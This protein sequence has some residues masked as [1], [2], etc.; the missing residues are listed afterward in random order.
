MMTPIPN[1]PDYALSDSGYVYN[2]KTKRRMKRQWISGVWRSHVRRA[3][4][5]PF[6]VRHD[7]ILN[8]DSGDMLDREVLKPIPDFQRYA[9][10]PY[11][12]VWCVRPA[13]Y[14]P[15]AGRPYIVNEHL[16]SK[17]RYVKLSDKFGKQKN[18]PVARIM[19]L[20][21]GQKLNT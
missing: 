17:R 3:D 4:G 21:Y 20:V 12:A 8:P 2:V 15:K 1:A 6:Y 14:G 5:T 11:G 19:E 10:T 13:V 18:V 9:V 16:R 7:R